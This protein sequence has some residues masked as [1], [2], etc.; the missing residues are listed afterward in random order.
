VRISRVMATAGLLVSALGVAAAPGVASAT[1]G[2]SNGVVSFVTT[3]TGFPQVL[4]VNPTSPPSPE[5]CA[6]YNGT[7][8]GQQTAGGADSE[9]YYSAAGNTVY[10]SSNR[11]G[12]WIVYSIG[13]ISTGNVPTP[14]DGAVAVTSPGTSNDYAPTVTADGTKLAFIRC[15]SGTSTCSLEVQSLVPPGAP[16]S[17][18]TVVPVA[19][20]SPLT[21]D[22]SRPEFDPA[23]GSKILYEGTDGHIHMVSLTGSFTERDLS[24][25]SGIGTG[26]TDEYPDFNATGT[27]LIF[28]SNRSGGHKLY[29]FDLTGST[30]PAPTLVWSTDPGV[31][32]EPIFA[33]DGTK[34]AWAQLGAGSVIVD[35]QIG[36]AWFSATTLSPGRSSNS[37]PAWQPIPSSPLLPESHY[38]IALPLG[39]I[40]VAA[41]VLVR[42]RRRMSPTS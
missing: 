2:T 21:G 26:Q 10:F 17:V 11:S 33:P 20:P 34:Y 29:L 42:R 23:D 37:E 7:N 8:G 3:C 25:E 35:Y 19:L 32:I 1:F 22:A 16:S 12:T 9:P 36:S 30:V 24:N 31:E 5:T 4:W 13:A 40:A 28:D 39:G 38:A 18:T 14:A 27:K 15:D 41:L 6:N